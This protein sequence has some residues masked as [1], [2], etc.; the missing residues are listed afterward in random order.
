IFHLP[1]LHRYIGY[2]HIRLS[3]QVHDIAHST[4]AHKVMHCQAETALEELIKTASCGP[5]HL[6]QAFG[7]QAIRQVVPHILL[8]R[9]HQEMLQRWPGKSAPLPSLADILSI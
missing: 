6:R 5:E 3:E 8:D 2:S 4:G 9:I 1:G 7:R